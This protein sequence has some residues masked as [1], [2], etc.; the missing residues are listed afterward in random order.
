MSRPAHFTAEAI[1]DAAIALVAEGGSGAA[2]LQA[3]AREVGGPTG[4]IYHRF[5]SRAAILATAWIAIHGDF[6]RRIETALERGGALLAALAIP[7]WARRDPTHARFLLLNDPA[8]LIGGAPPEA[9]EA[10]IARQEQALE[11]A[12]QRHVQAAAG[13]PAALG[14]GQTLDTESL[15]RGRFLIFD[16]PIGLTSPHLAA[17]DPVPAFVD[18]MIRELHEGV[19]LTRRRPVARTA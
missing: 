13:L 9:L 12:F 6:A 11:D 17:G 2:T 5:E 8:S 18:A 15:A 3:I 10:E 7:E 16:A 1:V 14:P 19:A 4:S